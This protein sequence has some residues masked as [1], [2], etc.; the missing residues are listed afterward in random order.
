MRGEQDVLS[1]PLIF[2]TISGQGTA[3]AVAVASGTPTTST[4]RPLKM[5]RQDFTYQV[6]SMTTGTSGCLATVIV[7]ASNDA[8][9]WFAVSSSTASATSASAT[10]AVTTVTAGVTVNTNRFANTRAVATVTGTG[11]AAV[12]LAS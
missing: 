2:D 4:S 11:S 1:Q 8:A 7:Q 10:A 6:N 12:W 9:N 5:G 3:T